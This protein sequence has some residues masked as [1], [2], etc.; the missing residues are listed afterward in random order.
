MVC[1]RMLFRVLIMMSWCRCWLCLSGLRIICRCWIR[2]LV[3]LLK[4]M[5]S[6]SKL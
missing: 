2:V 5:M 4:V 3:I 6:V 1:V